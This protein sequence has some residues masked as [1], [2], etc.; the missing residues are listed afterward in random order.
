MSGFLRSAEPVL[1][2]DVVTVELPEPAVERLRQS[3]T[4]RTALKL[5]LGEGMGRVVELRFRV[6]ETAAPGVASAGRV[7]P[8]T[9]RETRL[10]E[11]VNQEPTLARA[12]QELDLELLD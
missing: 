8:E 11:L 4:E 6:L 10:K 7:T 5:A 2:G 9:V 3:S 1:E 12:V